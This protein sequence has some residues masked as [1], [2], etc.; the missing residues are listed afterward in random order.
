[1]AVPSVE[2][3]QSLLGD[4]FLV[5]AVGANLA[6]E[7]KLARG[8]TDEARASLI[9]QAQA[10]F[11]SLEGVR[12]NTTSKTIVTLWVNEPIAAASS[13]LKAENDELR[14]EMAELRAMVKAMQ[15]ARKTGAV[16]NLGKNADEVAPF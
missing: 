10:K 2:E 8:Q 7:P 3:A 16:E 11:E 12:L 4:S 6:I 14:N 1:M 5:R 9:E 13:S 15:D